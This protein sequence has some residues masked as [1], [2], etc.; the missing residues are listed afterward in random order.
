MKV[1]FD[2]FLIL[3]NLFILFRKYDPRHPQVPDRCKHLC[4]VLC[5]DVLRTAEYP[6]VLPSDVL[7]P[8]EQQ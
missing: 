8:P 6:D 3:Q 5:Q 2:I 7:R 4:S 1:C